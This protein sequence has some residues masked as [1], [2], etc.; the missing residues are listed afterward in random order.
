MLSRRIFLI[1]L[2]WL[3]FLLPLPSC[4]EERHEAVAITQ[5]ETLRSCIDS[6]WKPG[7]LGERITITFVDIKLP[8]VI[9]HLRAVPGL[10]VSFIE[11][12]L[13]VQ[14]EIR[15]QDEP[16]RAVLGRLLDQA[17]GYKCAVIDDHMVIYYDEPALHKK[18]V[19][20]AITQQWRGRAARSYVEYLSHQVEEFKDLDVLLGGSGIEDSPVYGERVTLARDATVLEHLSQLLGKNPD[21]IFGLRYASMGGRYINF[22]TTMKQPVA[23]DEDSQLWE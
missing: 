23:A 15:V 19:N 9:S 14:I 13:P 5:I 1:K 7:L 18:V 22:G 3:F 20:V 2:S 8:Q 21:V 4:G 12:P 10:P 11:G 16:V 6:N 17:Q